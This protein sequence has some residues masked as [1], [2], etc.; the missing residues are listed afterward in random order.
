MHLFISPTDAKY[1]VYHSS[2]TLMKSETIQVTM[3]ETIQGVFEGVYVCVKRTVGYCGCVIAS[4]YLQSFDFFS[5]FSLLFLQLLVILL[6][7][8][9]TH[10]LQSLSTGLLRGLHLHTHTHTTNNNNQSMVT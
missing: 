9:S 7:E 3:S 4:V 2:F 10:F 1:L 5:V 6:L 8:F